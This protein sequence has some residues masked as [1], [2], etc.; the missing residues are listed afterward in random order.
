MTARGEMRRARLGEI[1]RVFHEERLLDLFRGAGFEENLPTEEPDGS[2]LADEEKRLPVPV[3]LRHALERLGP[4]FVKMGQYLATRAD[5]V[6]PAFVKELAR[7]QDDVSALPWEELRP[8]VEAE[9]GGAVGDHFVT[10]EETAMAS[11]SLGQVYRASLPDGT[12]VVVKVQRPG[13][14]ELVDLDL[15]ILHDLAVRVGGRLEWGVEHDV[16]GLAED[17]ATVLRAELDYVREGRS[18]DRLRTALGDDPSLVIPR[19]HWELTTPR[20]LTMDLVEGVPATKLEDSESPE[21]DRSSII[22]IGVGAYFRMIFEL[23]VYHADPHA[24]NLFALPDGRVGFVDFG[25]VAT[26]SRRNREA[27]FDVLMALLEDDAAA[28]TESVLLMTGIAPDIDLAALDMDI[29]KMIGEF[30]RQQSGEE[31]LDKLMASLLRVLRRHRLRVQ[32]EIATLLTTIGVLDGVATQIDPT[33]RMIEA[34]EPFARRLLPER[35]SPENLLK[36]SLGSARAY[37]R[38]FQELPLHATR[39]LRRLGEGELSVSVRPRDFEGL[40]DRLTAGVYVLAYAL[41]VGALIIGFSFLV[42]QPGLSQPE[43][44]GY[45]VVLFAATVSV[46]ALV[47]RMLG[48]EWR[49]RRAER[50]LRR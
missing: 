25:R 5:L 36:T 14:A 31:R 1:A 39:A 44:I 9:L 23:G 8:G 45:R 15:D 20:V 12:R 18:A 27:T 7:L 22:R 6:P 50:R 16:V 41:V 32:G 26:V 49:K 10:F 19:V 11:A 33:F 40:V 2:P 21:L 34:A 30:R 24:G 37:G 35:Y 4:V 13:V 47:A 38:F 17:F 43:R 48:D 46:I 28:A 29:A 42:G 3:R